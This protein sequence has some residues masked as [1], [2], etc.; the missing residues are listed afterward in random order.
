VAGG[1]D[2]AY[3]DLAPPKNPQQGSAPVFFVVVGCLWANRRLGH[4]L[5]H[6][7]PLVAATRVW[8]SSRGISSSL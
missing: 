8:V 4:S 7:R 6:L 5:R 2:V 3:R 1:G